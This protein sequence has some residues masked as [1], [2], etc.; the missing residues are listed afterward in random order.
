[1]ETEAASPEGR[2]RVGRHA[3]QPPAP[4]KHGPHDA[5][6]NG[7]ALPSP[8]RNRRS[9]KEHRGYAGQASPPRRKEEGAR[10]APQETARRAAR[11]A[12]TNH[13]S[14]VGE[15]FHVPVEE[16]R[17][18]FGVSAGEVRRH[19]ERTQDGRSRLGPTLSPILG[20]PHDSSQ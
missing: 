2:E 16:K 14:Y 11:V 5:G 12:K 3:S 4:A 15:V 8:G 17:A 10:G 20:G 18:D 7:A 13:T 1:M 19:P 6:E 9:G